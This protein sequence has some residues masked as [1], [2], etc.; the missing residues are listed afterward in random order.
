MSYCLAILTKSGIVFAS[1]SRT[2]AG[3]DQA[4]TA[5]KLH[6]FERPGE[7]AIVLLS[8]G[9]LSITQSIL[10]LLNA[11]FAH[12]RGLATAETMYA[13]ARIV[14]S[15]VRKIAKVDREHL[16]RD[17]I[18]FNVNFLLGGQ[19]EGEEPQ[20]FMIYPQG[21]PLQATADCPYLQI[22]ETKYG[23]PILDRAVKYEA[24]SL[25]Q[26]A[27]LALISLDSTMRSNL[28]VGPP[29]DLAVYGANE[30]AVRRRLRLHA[31]HPQLVVVR[32]QWE[33]ELRSAAERLPAIRFE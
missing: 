26:A 9:G 18:S 7:R 29:I 30:L 8:S 4:N 1:D 11:E 27:K 16:E 20:L 6:V 23:K 14:G 17:Q 15:A 19:I 33:R 10:T 3:L 12:G 22:G 21:N 25:E 2:N 13:A 31:D 5:R 32:T 28:T 24:T